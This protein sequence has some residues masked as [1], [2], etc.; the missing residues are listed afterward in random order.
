MKSCPISSKAFKW[1]FQQAA[2]AIP[3]L[4]F[5]IYAEGISASEIRTILNTARPIKVNLSPIS[6]PW[7]KFNIRC[8]Y[9]ERNGSN[10]FGDFCKINHR[11]AAI[12]IFTVFSSITETLRHFESKTSENFSLNYWQASMWVIAQDQI[13]SNLNYANAFGAFVIIADSVKHGI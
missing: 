3:K 11:G 10:S 1:R 12:P 2:F 8:D 4:I 6:S 9:R 5:N 13:M 7:L